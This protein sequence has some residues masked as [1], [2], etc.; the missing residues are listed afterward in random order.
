[1]GNCD[2]ALTGAALPSRFADLRADREHIGTQLK[3]L[4]HAIPRQRT[5]LCWKTS[6]WPGTSFPACPALTAVL[7]EAFDLQVL[8]D[9]ASGQVADT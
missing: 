7:F 4:A 9:K 8:W 3:A 6:R 1:V 5:P 2:D